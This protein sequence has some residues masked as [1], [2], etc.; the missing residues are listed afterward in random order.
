MSVFLFLILIELGKI[1]MKSSISKL[2]ILIFLIGV[3]ITELMLFSQGFLFLFGLGS[4][5]NYNLALFIASLIIVIGLLFIYFNQFKKSK[6]IV[7]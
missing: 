6:N 7:Y 3:L 2:G 5:N 4:I 1:D